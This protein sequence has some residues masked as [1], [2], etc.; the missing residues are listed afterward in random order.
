[1][2]HA[3]LFFCY[4]RTTEQLELSNQALDSVLSQ[5]IGPLDIHI[6]NNSSTEPT[7]QWLNSLLPCKGEHCIQAIH[8]AENRSPLLI[9]NEMSRKIYEHYDYMLGVPNDVILPPNCYSELLKFP[10][11]FVSATPVEDC[12]QFVPEVKQGRAIS[13]NTPMCVMLTRKWSWEAVVSTYGYFFDPNFQF[14]ASDCDLALRMAACGIVGVQTDVI[15]W[16]YRSAT[17]RLAP[18]EKR[19]EMEIQADSDRSYFQRKWGF[20]V[21]DAKYGQTAADINFRGI[22]LDK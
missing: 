10:R 20:P 21:T 5:D 11:G 13:T 2:R 9:S 1:M 7:K 4:N 14:Y 8:Y 17:L 6:I 18:P 15:F 22:S 3:V 16:H 19:R 12:P